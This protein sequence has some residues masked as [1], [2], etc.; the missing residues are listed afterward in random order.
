MYASYFVKDRVNIN[1]N[2]TPVDVKINKW[3][4]LDM[5]KESHAGEAHNKTIHK[6][7][8]HKLKNL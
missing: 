8:F 2:T 1:A 5:G 4:M 3:S 7:L 6:W